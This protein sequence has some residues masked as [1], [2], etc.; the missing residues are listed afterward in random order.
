MRSFIK[1]K[2][3]KTQNRFLIVLISNLSLARL[4]F[5]RRWSGPGG[6]PAQLC[7]YTAACLPASGWKIP[8]VWA[9][10]RYSRDVVSPRPPRLLVFTKH[11]S[12]R[13]E[14]VK[15]RDETSVLKSGGMKAKKKKEKKEG[16]KNC[17]YLLHAKHEASFHLIKGHFPEGKL[18]IFIL[19]NDIICL[20][21]YV[22]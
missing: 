5:S 10:A 6:L 12:E 2:K 15:L 3:K 16:E 11:I 8:L 4:F 14:P 21:K 18:F 17:C 13:C 22:F 1:K 9:A 19:Q 7:E 20:C